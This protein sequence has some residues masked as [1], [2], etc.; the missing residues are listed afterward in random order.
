MAAIYEGLG[1][2]AQSLSSVT[3][4]SCSTGNCTW[5]EY[6]SIGMC[7]NVTDISAFIVHQT[8]NTTALDKIFEV[9]GLQ[10]P[11]YSCYNYTLPFQGMG[12]YSI[13]D[14]MNSESPTFGNVFLSSANPEAE[15]DGFIA[16][17]AMTITS[18][19]SSSSLMSYYMIYQPGLTNSGTFSPNSALPKPVA[20]QMSL[21]FCLHTYSTNVSHGLVNTFITSSQNFPTHDIQSLT[22]TGF[23]DQLEANLST[24]T[25]GNQTFTV[26]VLGSV[27][28]LSTA[29]S[30]FDGT[31]SQI[32]TKANVTEDVYIHLF[33]GGGI[34][35]C[36]V[37]AGTSLIDALTNTTDTDPFTA[38][39]AFMENIAISLTNT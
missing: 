34:F 16:L 2:G 1:S 17:D 39:S 22:Q 4:S 19:P 31:C 23:N 26:D 36:E 7:V 11:G 14:T 29:H 20:Y 9:N 35:N 12:L 18:S 27:D 33:G 8:C 6:S 5:N 30:I 28:L 37:D 10:N 21:D 32:V 38:T 13:S 15:V 24:I 3:P 25:V